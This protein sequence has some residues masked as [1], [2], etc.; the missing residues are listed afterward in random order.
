MYKKLLLFIY[1]WVEKINKHTDVALHNLRQHLYFMD[2]EDRETDIYLVTYI[3]SGTTWMQVILHNLVTDGNMDFEHIY[4]VSPWPQNEA[5]NGDSVERINKLPSPRILKS[6][7]KYAFYNADCKNKF[8]FVYRDGKDVAVSLFHH[9]KNYKDP[10]LTFDENFKEY[11]S[12]STEQ[13]NWFKF[14][15]EWLQNKNNF[16][17][18]YVSYDDMKN[19]FDASLERIA[20]F[21]NIELT[22]EKLERTKKHASFEYM[23][24]HESKFGEIPPAHARLVYNQ[25]IRKGESGEGNTMMNEQQNSLFDEKFQKMIKPFLD[26]LQ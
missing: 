11:F 13:A 26:K 23:K 14:T 3:K 16:N 21:L 8:I 10:D 22:A 6:H 12:D 24:Q 7:D 15:N 1:K 19:N 2:Y 5:Y 17:I 18:L 4:D 20:S 9:N 25:F